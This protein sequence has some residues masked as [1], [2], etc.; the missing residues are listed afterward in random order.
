MSGRTELNELGEFAL[1]EHLTREVAIHHDET[2]LGIGDDAAIIENPDACT[3]VSTDLLIEGIH[4][5]LMYHPLKHL[6][7]KAVIANLS[8]IL[9]MNAIPRQITVSI[10][11]SNRFSVESLEE[12]YQGIKLA[13]DLYKIDLVGG[14]T[15]ASP[16]GLVI[17][18]TV[19]GTQ[20][21][22]K[23]VRRSGA[24][25]GDFLY[26]TGYLGGAYL[27]LQLLE[28]EK[29]IFMEHPDIQPQLSENREILER[30]L[31][32]EARMDIIRLLEKNHILPTAMI[33]LSDGLSSDLLHLCKQSGTGALIEE[34]NIPIQQ[35][36]QLM[37]M[38]FHLDPVTCALSGGEDYELLLCI[39]PDQQEKIRSLPSFYYIGEMT[40]PDQGIKLKTPQGNLHDI[41][42]QG[43][44]HF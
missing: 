28:R 8:D 37:A 4:F 11:A 20:K 25:P 32:P 5:D 38:E 3:L 39:S 22:E 23:I 16:R 18:V 17:S 1:I 13:C 10:A 15:T 19:I 35:E 40:S 44:K 43:W 12:L 41:T 26:V 30:I 7:Y 31:K 34:Q 14:D 42:A 33:D 27:G 24:K 21:K 29:R 2:I 36:A 6:G 9:A